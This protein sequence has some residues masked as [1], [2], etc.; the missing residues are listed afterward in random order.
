V[1]ERPRS[2]AVLLV[3]VLLCVTFQLDFSALALVIPVA[4]LL[5]Y[6]SRAVPAFAVGVGLAALLLAPWLRPRGEPRV[7]V[8]AGSGLAIT[9]IR[10]C[11][12]FNPAP[13]E[14]RGRDLNPRRT[15][16]HVRDFQSRSLDRSDTSPSATEGSRSSRPD[17]HSRC[18]TPERNKQGFV[19]KVR[20]A[21]PLPG[22]LR[23]PADWRS[24][25]VPVSDTRT[26]AARLCDKS[27]ISAGRDRVRRRLSVS[28]G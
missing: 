27:V 5:L 22:R 2:R 28:Q 16:R 14:R 24:W 4:V 10:Q 13:G 6:R 25:P 21:H 11:K 8:V 17:P 20:L 7:R 3:P 15:F 26:E 19:T 1:L 9:H 12:T 18:Q 23:Y